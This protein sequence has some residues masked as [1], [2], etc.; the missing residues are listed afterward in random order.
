MQCTSQ[1]GP[2]RRGDKRLTKS[3]H[4]KARA[5]G[6]ALKAKLEGSAG[7]PLIRGGLRSGCFRGA[8][9]SGHFWQNTPPFQRRP[10][11]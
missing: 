4:I 1:P 9:G 5:R 6:V 2:P 3:S 11:V 10:T 7:A 8:R